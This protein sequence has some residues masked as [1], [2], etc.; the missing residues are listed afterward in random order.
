MPDRSFPTDVQFMRERARRPTEEGDAFGA[1][2]NAR[3][4]DRDALK[5][6]DT[7]DTST[8]RSFEMLLAAEEREHPEDL[9]S[10]L[11]ELGVQISRKP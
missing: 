3:D 8:R 5:F 1:A 4:G 7:S 11:E 2:R 10:L 9:I 6:P